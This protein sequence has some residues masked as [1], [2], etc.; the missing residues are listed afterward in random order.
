M[1]KETFDWLEN[2]S[3]PDKASS[4]PGYTIST[5]GVNTYATNNKSGKVDFKETDATTVF[6]RAF[7]TLPNGGK[8]LTMPGTFDIKSNPMPKSNIEWIGSGISTI[9]NLVGISTVM[10]HGVHN[11]RMSNMLT[12]SFGNNVSNIQIKDN[13]KNISIDN[14]TIN[15]MGTLT[16]LST[17]YNGGFGIFLVVSQPINYIDTV[18]IT[19]CNINGNGGNDLIGG[20]TWFSVNLSNINNFGTIRNINISNNKIVHTLV[21][22][23]YDSCFD[24]VGINLTKFDN[25]ICNG[26]VQFGWEQYPTRSSQITNNIISPAYP[27]NYKKKY[28]SINVL[29]SSAATLP[30]TNLDILNN[31]IN[32]GQIYI[33]GQHGAYVS[34]S[35]IN[36]NTISAPASI[37]AMDLTYLS[38]SNVKNNMVSGGATCI[39][40]NNCKGLTITGGN[41]ANAN[42]G[43]NGNNNSI[44]NIISNI[45]FTNVKTQTV[46]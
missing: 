16:A 5:D 9:L 46:A 21:L 40:L 19:N 17:P 20:G 43:I 39:N 4:N 15:Q 14:V 30:Y 2:I 42:I 27:H 8:V 44:S 34:S 11:V 7:N 26:I 23:D 41:L 37:N 28:A 13:C 12:Q 33:L 24:M 29:V 45:G 3:Q 10:I 35:N 38:A 18:S 25:N 1:I 6:N 22:S 32:N 36:D 31:T